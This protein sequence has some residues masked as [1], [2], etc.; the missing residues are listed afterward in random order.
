MPKGRAGSLCVLVY[1]IMEFYLA[2]ILLLVALALLFRAFI[3]RRLG[4]TPYCRKCKFELTGLAGPDRCP[5]CG[6][7]LNHPRAIRIGKSR[8]RARP[9][10]W[11]LALAFLGG[12]FVG[13]DAMNRSGF[14]DLTSVK[15]AGLLFTEAYLLDNT[16]ASAATIEIEDR[17]IAGKLGPGWQDRI[18]ATALARHAQTWRSFPDAQWMFIT[19]AIDRGELSEDRIA[20]LFDDAGGKLRIQSVGRRQAAYPGEWVKVV[21]DIQWR[22]GAPRTASFTSFGSGIPLDYRFEI[23][24]IGNRTKIGMLNNASAFSVLQNEDQSAEI[25]PGVAM[26]KRYFY[27]V[28]IS[29]MVPQDLAPGTYRAQLGVEAIDQRAVM[30]A[31]PMKPPAYP[32]GFSNPL[33]KEL[34]AAFSFK[35][36]AAGSLDPTPV[37]PADLGRASEPDRL[38]GFKLKSIYKQNESVVA[39]YNIDW[40]NRLKSDVG[41]AG[42]LIFEQDGKVIQ[43]APFCRTKDAASANRMFGDNGFFRIELDSFHP[44]IV[45]V[46]YESYPGIA[47]NNRHRMDRYLQGPIQLEPFEIPESPPKRDQAMPTE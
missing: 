17:A 22:A 23:R 32:N 18:L 3:N 43:G 20:Q 6:R 28:A 30:G 10:W 33:T 36:A 13:I 14:I 16:R 21:A 27:D 26:P 45:S 31:D 39:E 4:D 24:P 47:R 2:L 37:T 15:P 8:V 11:G 44:G 1:S 25:V 46:R 35:V 9:M 42:V 19:D 38:V 29:F 12:A 40:S 5:E 41:V 7:E 34:T